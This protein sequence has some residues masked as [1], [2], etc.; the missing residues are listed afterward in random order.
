V[1]N[2]PA[3]TDRDGRLHFTVDL[4]PSHA[5]E[6]YSPAARLQ[7]AAGQYSFVT[8]KVSIAGPV[9]VEA[10]RQERLP[11]TGNS[12]AAALLAGALILAA[13]VMNRLR[14]AE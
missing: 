2:A 4:G 9:V 12:P 8:K 10:A 5:D 6:Q 13:L 3:N 14:T 1:D 7:E 11:E